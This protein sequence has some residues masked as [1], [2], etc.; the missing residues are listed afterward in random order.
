MRT[1]P[2][3]DS[4]DFNLK[5]HSIVQ[6]AE[7]LKTVK[8]G[9]KEVQ[10]RHTMACVSNLGFVNTKLSARQDA[11]ELRKGCKTEA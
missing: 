10:G 8:K 7:L 3:R 1:L 11:K 2:G 6:K 5:Q 9:V 4:N